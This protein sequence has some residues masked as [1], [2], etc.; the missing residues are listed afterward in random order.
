[1]KR[2]FRVSVITACVVAGLGI[3][4]PAAPAAEEGTHSPN[5]KHIKTV[6]Y[7][8]KYGQEKPFGTDLEFATLNVNGQK[9]EFALGGTYDNGLQIVDIT[10][11]AKSK[12]SERLRLLGRSGR[13]AGLQARAQDLRHVRSR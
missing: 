3:Q 10:N 5:L 6:K 1:M 4:G 12:L 2:L 7:E 13:R 11:P 8:G 9:R